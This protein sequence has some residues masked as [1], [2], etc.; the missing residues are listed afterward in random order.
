MDIL[1]IYYLL[2]F[3]L[4]GIAGSITAMDNFD[5][6]SGNKLKLIFM[7][8]YMVYKLANE[9]LNIVGIIILEIFTTFS[10][11][12]LNVIIF[13]VICLYYVLLV[14]CKVF[15]FVFKKR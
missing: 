5:V 2:V 12:F 11:W 3:L 9:N 1:G 7:Y 4:V 15:Y 10:V 8:Q 13:V 14:I 6:M